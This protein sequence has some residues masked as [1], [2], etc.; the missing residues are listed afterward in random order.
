MG[1]VLHAQRTGEAS[2][3]EV[4][5]AADSMKVKD[6]KDFAS[7]KHKDLPEKKREV[8]EA[9]GTAKRPSELKKK[10][11]LEAILQRVEDLKKKKV[12][13]EN[14]NE[15][16]MSSNAMSSVLK[17]HKYSKK[18]LFDMSKKSTKEGRHGEAHALYKEFQKEGVIASIKGGIERDKKARQEKRYDK[19]M[20]TKGSPERK[21]EAQHL[22]N[23]RFNMQGRG[24]T[25]K[26]DSPKDAKRK[27]LQSI[28]DKAS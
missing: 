7:T 19:A 17:G 18:Q 28:L 11:K 2:T 15:K 14:L 4:A 20:K 25:P 5:D 12:N 8:K 24:P 23:V 6:V 10:A 1:A 3:P 13:E 9:Y 16:G 21:A 26:S 22:R 27:K